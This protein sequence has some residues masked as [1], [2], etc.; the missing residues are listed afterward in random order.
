MPQ[1]EHPRPWF[2]LC[3]NRDHG[4][5]N[6]ERRERYR[7]VGTC[8]FTLYYG[9]NPFFWA[10]MWYQRLQASTLAAPHTWLIVSE[11]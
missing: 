6:L 9:D 3:Q 2:R 8:A 7:W 4:L 1:A 11:V 10:C 5:S